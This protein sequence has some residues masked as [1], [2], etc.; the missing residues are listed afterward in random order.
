MMKTFVCRGCKTPVTGRG[1]TS[2]D[3]GGDANLELVDKFC[4]LGD[5]LSIDGFAD[6]AVDNRIE[7]G[8]NKFTQLVPVLT[9]KDISLIVRK[10]LYSSCVRSSM[11]HRSETW[12]I[13]K[14]NKKAILWQ[15]LPCDAM[16]KVNIQTV[17]I[18]N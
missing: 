14:E 6:A 15:R 2:V 16:T 12:P 1:H 10:R 5:M 18:T 7:T 9:N 13:R 4:Y 11:L 3:V 17:N 8:W